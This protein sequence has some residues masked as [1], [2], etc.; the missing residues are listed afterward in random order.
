MCA[1]CM[2]VSRILA[3]LMHF[4][5]IFTFHFSPFLLLRLG[6]ARTPSASP[7]YAHAL[8]H[9]LIYI[10]DKDTVNKVFVLF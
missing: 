6:G 9:V 1:H 10:K 7:G 3:I 8:H 4:G 5:V 2:D